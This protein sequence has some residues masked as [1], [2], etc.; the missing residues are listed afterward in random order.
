M[1]KELVSIIVPSYN[2]EDTIETYLKSVCNQSYPNIEAIVV[3]D[4][5]TDSTGEIVKRFT[6]VK[7]IKNDRNLGMQKSRNIGFGI[8][9]GEYVWFMD[10]DM[11]L[12]P[13]VVEA[14]V[15]TVEQK[16]LDALMIPER[17]RGDSIWAKCRGLEKIINDD[18]ICKNSIRFMKREV[19]DNVGG[20]DA[21]FAAEDM[22]FHLRA[23]QLGYKYELLK[24]CNI[25]HYE[26]TSIGKMLRKYYKYGKSMVPYAKLYPAESV[27]Q[28]SFFRPAYLK[29][30]KLL[31][32]HPLLTSGLLFLKTLQYIATSMGILHYLVI[33]KREK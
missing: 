13:D 17:S 3:D 24:G 6:D 11:E 19:F 7:Y 16:D 20:Y 10:S 14:C 33:G 12:T 5:S 25:F 2:A 31:L 8:S 21:R 32:L 9:K 27:K 1:G 28:F 30:Y 15:R 22:D 23:T 29:N 26:V 4:G 18:D